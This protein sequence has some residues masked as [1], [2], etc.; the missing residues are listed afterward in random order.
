MR[1]GGPGR[2][3]LHGVFDARRLVAV[4]WGMRRAVTLLE[5]L[6]VIAILAVLIGLLLP[7]LQKV[8]SAA[9]RVADQNNLKQLGLGLNNFESVNGRLCPLVTTLPSG[10][11]QWWFGE[12]GPELSEPFA[13]YEA[14]AAGGHLMPY[15]ENNKNALQAPAKSPG[16]VFLRYTG[17]SGGYGYNHAYLAPGGQGVRI[18]QVAATSQTVAFASAVTC[19]VPPGFSQAVMFEAGY[20]H[21]PSRRDPGV[22]FRLAGRLANVLFVDGHVEAHTDPT[23]NPPGGPTAVPAVLAVRDAENIFDLGATDDLWDLN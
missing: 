18:A 10:R 22:H 16:K 5:L 3:S 23:R 17:A 20:V 8:R 4:C 7:A 6:V 14:D 9:G 21:P 19:S 2:E 11:R 15:L 1:G 13:S 12:T